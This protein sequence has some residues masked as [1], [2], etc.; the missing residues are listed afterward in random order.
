M[1]YLNKRLRTKMDDSTRLVEHFDRN[2]SLRGYKFGPKSFQID[3]S[4]V[5]GR[6]PQEMSDEELMRSLTGGQ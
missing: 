1:D 4:A 6:K 3:A 2:Q 5:G